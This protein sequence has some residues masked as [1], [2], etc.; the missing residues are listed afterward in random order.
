LTVTATGGTAPFQYSLN[1]GA[2]QSGNT[3]TVAAGTHT[4]TVRDANQCTA[5]TSAVTVTQPS[6]I[7][8]S[9][10]AGTIACND[11]TTTVTITATGG[12]APYT[13]TG[14]FTRGPGTYSFVVTDANEC[15]KTVSVTLAPPGPCTGG[16]TKTST[17][18]QDFV[19]RR[20][21]GG[22]FVWFNSVFDLKERCGNDPIII[23]V[24]NAKIRY[25]I[26]QEWITL[27]VPDS[28]ITLAANVHY[29]TEKFLNGRW[30]VKAPIMTYGR[31]VFM[32]G[33]SYKVPSGG[34]PAGLD[35][36][37]WTADIN[38]NREGVEIKWKWA[39]A[40]YNQWFT[41]N[42]S[43]LDVKT[44]D[45]P[46][47]NPYHN[48]HK[49]ATPE[50]YISCLK[51]GGTGWGGYNY[52]GSYSHD[53]KIRC[54][55]CG[56]DDE[57]NEHHHK[58][59]VPVTKTGY[60]QD[61]TDNSESDLEV[62]VAPNPSNSDFSLFIK[63]RDSKQFISIRIRNANGEVVEMHQQVAANR[64]LKIGKNSWAAGVYLAEIIQGSQRKVVRLVKVN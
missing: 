21:R 64:N 16:C 53:K 4:V 59:T 45:G 1:G 22:D 52:T 63:S 41:T 25:R 14:T 7:T 33:L 42:H 31:N 6:A 54:G 62:T 44:I 23:T 10:S 9:A 3:F 24:T 39:A 43:G 34:I 50:N 32:A 5:T 37:K 28:R 11:T 35:D 47:Q 2:F 19:N 17:I 8:V 49:A 26:N 15:V 46:W 30:E 48:W 55:N 58:E 38:I 60:P 29:A 27:N 18:T 13:G 51:A 20:I 36:V 56:C 61:E 57:H 12:T 40:V